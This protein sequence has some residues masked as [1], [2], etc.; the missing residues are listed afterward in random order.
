MTAVIWT[1]QEKAILREWW[2]N[3]T[4]IRLWQHLIPGKSEDAIIAKSRRMKLGKRPVNRKPTYV[5]SWICIE[6]LLIDGIYRSTPEIAKRTG[7]N[8]SVVRKQ[9]KDRIR[10][11]VYVA[12][13]K[14]EVN[15]YVAFFTLGANKPNVRKPKPKTHAAVQRAF[16]ERRK[17]FN[18]EAHEEHLKQRRL[19]DA[20]NRPAP[21]Q[22]DLAAS[23]LFNQC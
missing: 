10:V 23:W 18:P 21:Q 2:P 3:S 5:Q 17:K 1:E 6:Q 12:E 13:W 19:R 4:P 11:Q 15:K 16:Y 8:I 9:L 7:F 20:A 22:A 14:Y